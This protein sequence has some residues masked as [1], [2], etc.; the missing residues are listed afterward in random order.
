MNKLKNED[1][2]MLELANVLTT[3]GEAFA[4]ATV[5]RTAGATSAKPGAKAIISSDGQILKGWVGGGCIRTSVATATKTAIRT[6]TPQLISVMPQDAIDEIGISVGE[7]YEGK[8]VSKNGCPSE[9]TVDIFIEPHTPPPQLIIYGKAPVAEA[10]KKLAPQFGWAVKVAKEEAELNISRKLV[11]IVVA[12]QGNNDLKS[13][14]AAIKVKPT[15]ISFV[16]SKRKFASLKAKLANSGFLETDIVNVKA[17]A[18]L[19]IGAVTP[20]EISLSILA[21]LM[22]VRKNFRNGSYDESN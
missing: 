7:E 21:E 11:V 8:K 20:E 3:S 14:S 4:Y 1:N 9:G 17:P 6:G 10:L 13:L 15:F 2:N 19:D 18:G 16:G 5:I 12:T 22:Q